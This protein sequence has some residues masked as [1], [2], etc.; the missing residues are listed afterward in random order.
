MKR[1]AALL[2]YLYYKLEVHYVMQISLK[3]WLWL[4]VALP[5]VLAFLRYLSWPIAV[6]LSLVG[7]L[8]L[9]GAAWA[10]R[11]RY[12]VFEPAQISDG[13]PTL[14]SS[15]ATAR[16][17]MRAAMRV[18]EPVRCWAYGSF[19][20]EGKQRAIVN[21]L[22]QVSFVR[23]REHIVMAYV[24]RTRFLLMAG[25]AKGEV[26]WWY[27]F[28]MPDLVREVQPGYVSCGFRTRPGLKLG[29]ESKG[30]LGQVKEVYLVFED[31]GAMLR[32]VD[33]LR[34]DVAAEAFL[35]GDG[36]GRWSG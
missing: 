4:L 30:E 9:A 28:F 3:N 33:N 15:P 34:R 6:F 17:A 21:E 18:D 29:Y 19:A 27:A 2:L 12:L 25:S 16:A 31:P 7:L 23:T 13:D 26:G 1:V 32:M 14:P 24:R 35:S 8:S 11:S 5:P 20:V 22:A 36:S 10:K